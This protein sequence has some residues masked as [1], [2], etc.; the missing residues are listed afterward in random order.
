MKIGMIAHSVSRLNGGVSE[1]IRL[2]CEALSATGQTEI[3]LFTGNDAYL[4]EDIRAFPPVKLKTAPI[5]GKSRYGFSPGLVA[6]MLA[7]DVDLLHVHG[8]WTNHAFAAWVW[9]KKTGR[10]VVI[11]PHGMLEEWILKRRVVLKK[12]IWR[13]YLRSLVR[14]ATRLHVLT[15]KERGD[16]E[17]VLPGADC[18]IIPNF[19][20]PAP[21]AFTVQRPFWWRP[22]FEDKTVFVFLGRLHV[23]KGLIELCEAWGRF[24]QERPELARNAVLILCGWNDGIPDFESHVAC[25]AAAFGN[26]R[27]VGPQYG[28]EKWR[29]LAAGTFTILPSKSEGLPMSVLEG[30]S[31]GKPAIMTPACN[32]DI[33]F[34]TNAALRIGESAD[35]I[36]QGL[37]RANTMPLAERTAMEQA[38]RA[39]IAEHY[40]S[41]AFAGRMLDVYR[42]ALGV[43][44]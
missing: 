9:W 32:L 39:L 42:R 11:T 37:I 4:A 35:D 29:S 15:L 36:L 28:D 33:G 3:T 7:A 41:D 5:L 10:P 34:E 23:K 44:A 19:V 8:I 40:S 30:W 2:A 18:A 20:P 14:H 16:V 1:S 38:S 27:F 17:A 25:A 26:A 43:M 21:A 31:S 6:R 22:D 24:C 12:A 13:L